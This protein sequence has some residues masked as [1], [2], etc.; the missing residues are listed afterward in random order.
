MKGRNPNAKERRHMAQV[1]EIGCIACLNMG[2]ETP[3][4]Y[5]LI[6]HV[7]GKTKENA[8]LYVLPLCERHHGAGYKTGIHNNKTTWQATHGT[9]AELLCQVNELLGCETVL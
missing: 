2:I 7:W 5:T 3:P 1:R 6:H 4:E 8:H 9:Q